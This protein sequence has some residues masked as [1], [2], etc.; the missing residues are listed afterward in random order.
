MDFLGWM[1]KECL[2]RC[3]TFAESLVT[4]RLG[5]IVQGVY[6][7]SRGSWRGAV[8]STYRFDYYKRPLLPVP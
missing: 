1:V 6:P 3:V 5:E 8:L 4:R 2:K 7:L